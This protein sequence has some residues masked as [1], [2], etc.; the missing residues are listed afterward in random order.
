MRISR[1]GVSRGALAVLEI[2][3]G[4]TLPGSTA[5]GQTDCASRKSSTG[6]RSSCNVGRAF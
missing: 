6:D 3:G 1:T 4:L 5:F 2:A